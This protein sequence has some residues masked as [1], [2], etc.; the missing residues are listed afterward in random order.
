MGNVGRSVCGNVFANG[1]V[2]TPLYL[3]TDSYESTQVEGDPFVVNNNLEI[4]WAE[5]PVGTF[6]YQFYTKDIFQNVSYSEEIFVDYYEED[7]EEL[8]EPELEEN[9]SSDSVGDGTS[10]KLELPIGNKNVTLNNITAELDVPAQII[11]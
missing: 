3:I 4:G 1:D 10:M 11:I 9:V 6:T 2:I 8:I 5:L 7:S